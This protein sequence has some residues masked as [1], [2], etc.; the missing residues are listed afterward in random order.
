MSRRPRF[1]P[2]DLEQ[3]KAQAE[4]VRDKLSNL[5]KRLLEANLACTR[6]HFYDSDVRRL[7][8]SLGSKLGGVDTLLA[9]EESA[10]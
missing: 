4:E 7:A 5:S 6:A 10:L 3:I 2:A 1:T 9:R 8:D